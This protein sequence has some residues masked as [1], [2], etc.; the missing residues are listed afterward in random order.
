MYKQVG[1]V[2][3]EVEKVRA[4]MAVRFEEVHKEIAAAKNSVIMWVV[5]LLTVYGAAV[6]GAIALLT[7]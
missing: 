4:E 7:R 2:R 5:G 6:I 3:A 1:Q